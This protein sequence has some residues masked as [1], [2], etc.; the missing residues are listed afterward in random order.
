MQDAC[1][2]VV[3][4][5]PLASALTLKRAFKLDTRSLMELAALRI[6]LWFRIETVLRSLRR[7]VRR[8][9]RAMDHTLIANPCML[10]CPFAQNGRCRLC[11]RYAD[12]HFFSEKCFKVMADVLSRTDSTE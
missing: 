8:T 9:I 5:L 12:S 1:D 11:D 10:Y 3:A 2:C 6:Q 4:K 7:D